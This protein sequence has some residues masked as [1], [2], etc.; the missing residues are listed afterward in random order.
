MESLETTDIG[1]LVVSGRK[2]TRCLAG[3]YDYI[4]KPIHAK[5]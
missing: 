4:C 3:E 5:L 1:R 2:G